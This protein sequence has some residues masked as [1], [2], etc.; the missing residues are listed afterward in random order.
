MR[1]DST[2]ATP[3]GQAMREN[4]CQAG[5]PAARVLRMRLVDTSGFQGPFG[6][7]RVRDSLAVISV[8]FGDHCPD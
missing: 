1:E 5:F 4:R 8:R 3:K 7:V 6:L 2:T